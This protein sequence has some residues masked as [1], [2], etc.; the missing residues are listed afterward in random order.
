MQCLN[1]SSS[2]SSSPWPETGLQKMLTEHDPEWPEIFGDTCVLHGYAVGEAV[3]PKICRHKHHSVYLH[4]VT[5]LVFFPPLISTGMTEGG[6]PKPSDGK[7]LSLEAPGKPVSCRVKGK[8]SQLPCSCCHGCCWNP[9]FQRV[10]NSQVLECGF[11]FISFV[12]FLWG[13]ETFC[14][15][16][17]LITKVVYWKKHNE[18]LADTISKL[19]YLCDSTNGMRLGARFIRS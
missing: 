5:P 4:L 14:L 1:F 18:R 9:L 17:Y 15:S 13:L 8:N 12:S 3:A 7:S 11:F 6:S 10:T 2:V 19:S 16:V